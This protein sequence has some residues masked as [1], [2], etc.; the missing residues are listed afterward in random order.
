MLAKAR[1]FLTSHFHQPENGLMQIIL[2]NGLVFIALL[3][4]KTALVLAGYKAY[5]QA[6]YQFLRLPASWG[7]AY[8]H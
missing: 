3:L 5:Y 8:A 7:L 2:I 1:S 6:L 4:I